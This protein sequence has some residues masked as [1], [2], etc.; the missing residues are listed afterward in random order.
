MRTLPARML[1]LF[2]VSA[3]P[4][5]CAGESSLCELFQARLRQQIA[6]LHGKGPL[7][8][9]KLRKA[10]VTKEMVAEAIELEKP[11]FAHARLRP[12]RGEPWFERHEGRRPI[13]VTAGH[14]T[15]PLREGH[16]RFPDS[17]TGALALMLHRYADVTAFVTT[18]AAPCDPNGDR[19]DPFKAELGRIL[20]SKKPVLVLD[21]H[22]SDGYRP[23]EL[24]FGTRQ[25]RS[26]RGREDL[27]QRLIAVLRSEGVTPLSRGYFD[28][29]G[30][31]TLSAYVSRHGTPC[32]QLEISS[33]R[34]WP[35]RDPLWAHRFAQ[36]LQG[37]LRFIDS[38]ETVSVGN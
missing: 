35:G 24:D 13:V 18:R 5:R 10:R 20:E 9:S 1:F 19:M 21:L 3:A 26:L 2:F 32:I 31:G 12:A 17:G 14:A 30:E 33:T 28:A 29:L 27:L 25:G 36:L 34:L 7:F 4:C 23:Y 11:F 37:L 16:R 8:P 6:Q 15:G 38:V 22:A